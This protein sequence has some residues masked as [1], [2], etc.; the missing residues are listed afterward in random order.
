M[1]S[2]FANQIVAQIELYTNIAKYPSGV[3]VLPKYPDEKVARLQ[4]KK[5]SAELT[6]GTSRFS[7]E[8]AL[9]GLVRA[10][11]LQCPRALSTGRSLRTRPMFFSLNPAERRI[12]ALRRQRPPVES[13]SCSN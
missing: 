4:L 2:S 7:C 3:H 1:S 9:F 8:T 5:L 6:V 12:L 10:K 11:S 13:F